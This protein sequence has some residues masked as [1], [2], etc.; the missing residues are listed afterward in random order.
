MGYTHLAR[1]HL[2]ALVERPSKVAKAGSA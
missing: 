1:E 2:R